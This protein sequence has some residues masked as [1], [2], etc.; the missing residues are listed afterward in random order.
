[1]QNRSRALRNVFL[2]KLCRF[3][4]ARSQASSLYATLLASYKDEDEQEAPWERN[5]IRRR[6]PPRRKSPRRPSRKARRLPRKKAEVRLRGGHALV[7]KSHVRSQTP[8]AEKARRSGKSCCKLSRT[9][10]KTREMG[11]SLARPQQGKSA[12]PTRRLPWLTGSASP[13]RP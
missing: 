10:P 8:N 13:L 9:Q 7:A 5:A 6:K 2:G 12:A 3:R 4:F 11:G 1:M